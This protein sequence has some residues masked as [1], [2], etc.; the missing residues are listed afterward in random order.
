MRDDIN[1]ISNDSVLGF[2][3]CTIAA[4]P[5]HEIAHTGD[6]RPVSLLLFFSPFAA[7]LSKRPQL[8]RRPTVM[9]VED[10]RS[11]CDWG[12]F[13]NAGIAEGTFGIVV[14]G[15]PTLIHSGT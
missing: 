15:L 14:T 4:D 11:L 9:D 8:S 1:E 3:D 12:Q 10:A 13:K 5:K 7:A 2:S 6:H